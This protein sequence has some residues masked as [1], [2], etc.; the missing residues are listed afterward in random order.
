MRYPIRMRRQA[1]TPH[2]SPGLFLIISLAALSVATALRVPAADDRERPA[3]VTEIV[4]PEDGLENPFGVAFDDQGDMLIAEYLGG[5]L[6]RWDH[7]QLHQLAK[8]ATFNGMHNLSRTAEGAVYI[9]D[10]RAN[11]IQK[12]D[13]KTGKVTIIAG[14]GEGAYHGDNGPASEAALHDPISISLSP[15]D[16]RLLISDI[17]NRRIRS[18]DLATGIIT[19]LAG[20]GKRGRP[21]DGALATESPLFDPRAAAEDSKGNL[22]ILERSGH[23]L[24]VVTPDGRITT[25]A[26]NGKAHP[27]DGPALEAGLNGPKHLCIDT[28]DRVII[29][30]AENHLIKRYDPIQKTLTTILDAGPD[31]SPLNRPHGVWVTAD[32]TLYVCDSWNDRVLKVEW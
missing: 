24:R 16:Q 5:R 7:Q 3:K 9:S 29:A 4:G 20:N 22:Y 27:G 30:D 1:H 23:A 11:L 31:G 15:D 18:I 6:W 13:E 26:G 2:R 25:V 14:T 12:L 10:T 21:E 32:G 19:T 17:K 8:D 28:D